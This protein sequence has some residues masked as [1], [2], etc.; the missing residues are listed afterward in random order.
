MDLGSVGGRRRNP[1]RKKS[2][3]LR[4]DTPG[5]WKGAEDSGGNHVRQ[6]KKLR[7]NK[8]GRW[9]GFHQ[10]AACLKLAA[11]GKSRK[12]GPPEG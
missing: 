11:G 9:I 3:F 4:R 10:N 1:K 8:R 2:V 6:K 12:V 5:E 7:G